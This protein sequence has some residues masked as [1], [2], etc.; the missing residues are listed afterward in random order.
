ML[1]NEVL[2]RELIAVNRLAT[3]TISTSEVT[4]LQNDDRPLLVVAALL[5]SDHRCMTSSMIWT[6]NTTSAQ[7]TQLSHLKHELG[8]HAMEFAALV[9]QGHSAAASALLTCTL[10]TMWDRSMVPSPL[11]HRRRL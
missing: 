6:R 9:V 3:G 8:N 10:I 4:T 1:L 11:V 2:V 5:L 7:G